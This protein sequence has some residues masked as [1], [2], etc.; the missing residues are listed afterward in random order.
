MKSSRAVPILL[1]VLALAGVRGGASDDPVPGHAYLL[2]DDDRVRS[3]IVRPTPEGYILRGPAGEIPFERERVV[4]VGRSLRNVYEYRARLVPP[5]DVDARLDL[6]QWCLSHGLEA[7]AKGELEQIVR[8]DPGHERAAWLLRKFRS[9]SEPAGKSAESRPLGDPV[10]AEP[11][12]YLE[13]FREGHGRQ[14]LEAFTDRFEMLLLNRCGKCHANHRYGGPFRLYQ[15]AGGAPV[16]LH[17][18]ARNLRSVL[19]MTDVEA[20]NQSPLLYYAIE[21]HGQSGVPPLGGVNDPKYR[22]LRD[23]VYRVAASSRMDLERVPDDMSPWGVPRREAAPSAKGAAESAMESL[24][25]P[26]SPDRR[27]LRPTAP[28][29]GNDIERRPPLTPMADDGP[30]PA[31]S[32]HPPAPAKTSDVSSR[33][34]SSSARPDPYDP[35]VFNRLYGPPSPARLDPPPPSDG[36]G[37]TP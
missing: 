24:L 37:G 14:T 5:G 1:G 21:P 18:T 2:L 23:W 4:Y 26:R 30:D 25:G 22:D 10:L 19:T 31:P 11:A 16:D 20:P 28:Q 27:Y 13:R 15:R 8:H 6:Y 12:L 7:E 3:G 17:L 32:T 9:R 35:E 36:T 29:P 33:R 34:S